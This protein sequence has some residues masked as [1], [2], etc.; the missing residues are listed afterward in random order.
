MNT[1]TCCNNSDLMRSSTHED[2]PGTTIGHSVMSL[3]SQRIALRP[4]SCGFFLKRIPTV[5]GHSWYAQPTAEG[6]RLPVNLVA[7]A[8][9]GSLA[10]ARELRRSCAHNQQLSTVIHKEKK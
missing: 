6:R 8:A 1:P 9:G 7:P 10:Y 3:P 5:A 4:E 2:A